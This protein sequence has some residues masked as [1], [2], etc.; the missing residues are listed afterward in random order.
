M[1]AWELIDEENSVSSIIVTPRSHIV[2]QLAWGRGKLTPGQAGTGS[3][4]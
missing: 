1:G 3:N 4:E 2:I